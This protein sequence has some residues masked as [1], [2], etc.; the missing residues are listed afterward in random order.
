MNLKINPLVWLGSA[1]V[2]TTSVA[3]LAESGQQIEDN[4]I[5]L[6]EEIVVR[7]EKTSR[8]LSE[9]ASSVLAKTGEDL[10]SM[11]GVQMSGDLL[12]HIPNIVTVEPGNDAPAVRG[13]D[14]TG[15]A[16]GANAFLAG[17]RPRLT[18]QV[19][20]RTLGF[21]ESV[22]QS[23]SL[24]DIDQVEV[25]RGPQS[26]LQGRNS[27]AGAVVMTTADPSFEWQGKVR[28]MVGQQQHRG[29]SFVVSGPLLGDTLAFRLAG[30]S[31]Q[32]KTAVDF[33]PYAEEDEP[34]RYRTQTLRGKLLFVPV[35]GFRTLLTAGVT[36]GRAPQSERV[37]RPFEEREAEFPNQPTFHSRNVYGVLDSQ[38]QV[39]DLIALDVALQTTDFHTDRHALT[40]QG[41][42][43][44]DGVEKVFQPMLRI[45]D[46]AYDTVSGFLAAYVFRSEQDEYIDLFGGGTFRDE[47]DN[48]AVL[49]ELNWRISE[50]MALILGARYEEESRYRVGG[51]GPLLIDFEDE[52]KEFLPKISVS[53]YPD[54]LWT[55]GLSAGRGYNGGGAGIT[56]SSPFVDYSYDPEYIWNY[57][58]FMRGQ[59]MDQRM[60]V[61]ANV[62]YNRF[63]DMQLPF[64]LASGSTVIRN[65]DK[66]TTWGLEAGMDYYLSEGNEVYL[67]LGLLKTRVDR[68]DDDTV[69]G[70]QLARSPAYSLDTGV[71]ATPYDGLELTL[72][73]LYTDAYYSDATNT[74]RG[75]VDPYAVVNAQVSYAIKQT[76]L[77]LSGKNLLDNDSEVSILTGDTAADDSA[78]LL[79]PRTLL[80][81]VEFGF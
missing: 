24:W 3:S 52:Y 7:G 77:F 50:A 51:A 20:G 30:D 72:S 18:Y 74:P 8:P 41:N 61:T 62:F 57:E 70:N 10:D 15:P 71:L 58:G 44:I 67:N 28:A 33:T 43:E 21:N 59:L 17:T 22:F 9:T 64:N 1:V 66:A 81:G 80:A 23:A 19:D 27:I 12:E 14:G 69:E 45:G 13:I 55:L 75:K 16:S 49:G 78:T 65:A 35:E 29:G 48:D 11:A 31:Q 42:L 56:L 46:A 25:Y 32:H 37:V 79:Q 34:D 4:R 36:D 26:T 60:G 76:R 6:I 39:S 2:A 47:T 54:E 68:Y 53:F 40:G 38:W 73:V 63:S 5:V